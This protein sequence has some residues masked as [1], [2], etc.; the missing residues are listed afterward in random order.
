MDILFIQFLLQRNAHLINFSN[1]VRL[2]ESYTMF[3]KLRLRRREGK[4]NTTLTFN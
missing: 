3:Q 2:E 1:C 4:V